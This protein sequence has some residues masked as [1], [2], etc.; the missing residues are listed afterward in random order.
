MGLF[1]QFYDFTIPCT[2]IILENLFSKKVFENN[3]TLIRE[4]HMV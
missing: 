2:M 1:T 4:R 3:I